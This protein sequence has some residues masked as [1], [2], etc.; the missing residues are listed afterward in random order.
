MIRYKLQL[1]DPAMAPAP[2]PTK[3]TAAELIAAWNKAHPEGMPTLRM[4]TL[5]KPATKPISSDMLSALYRRQPTMQRATFTT[6][7][8][9]PE[10]EEPQVDPKVDPL[11]EPEPK[12][13]DPKVDEPLPEEETPPPP[14]YD[15]SSQQGGGAEYDPG[16]PTDLIQL[17]PIEFANGQSL[18]H[19]VT[20]TAASNNTLLY[21]GAAALIAYLVLK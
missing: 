10:P 17:D 8:P 7:P 16:A 19:V 9:P 20:K 21:V 3:P 2:E 15:P 13:E 11:P 5:T 18:P 4:A 14:E 1:G 6:T 12:D